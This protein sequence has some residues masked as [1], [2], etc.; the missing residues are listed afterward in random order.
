MVAA[1]V[2]AA[3]AAAVAA[4]AVTAV[5]L[6]AVVDLPQ[7]DL[8]SLTVEKPVG[9]SFIGCEAAERGTKAQEVDMSH[10]KG[11]HLRFAPKWRVA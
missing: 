3:V 4:E 8:S 2:A 7:V 9:A 6:A 11:L 5:A 1:V 10:L